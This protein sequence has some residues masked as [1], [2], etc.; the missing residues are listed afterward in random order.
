MKKIFRSTL[1]LSMALGLVQFTAC[2]GARSTVSAQS[3]QAAAYVPLEKSLLWEISGNGLTKPSYLFGTIHLI[4]KSEFFFPATLEEKLKA[5]ERAT[6]EID[7]DEMSSMESMF[8]I[9]GKAFMKDGLTLRDLL[10]EAEYKVVEDHFSEKGLP[11]QFL[12]RMKPMLLATFASLDLGQGGLS[13]TKSYEMEIFARVNEQNKPSDGLETVDDQLSIFD[14]IPYQTQAKMLM[15][16]IKSSDT[17]NEEYKKLIE[18]YKKQDIETLVKISVGEGD[19]GV[20]EHAD[21]FLY[22]RNRNW[23]PHMSRM[24][25]EKP[26]FFAVGAGHLGGPQG[27]INLLKKAGFKV[28]AVK[29]GLG[30]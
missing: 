9:I 1:Y 12:D 15:E 25:K 14:S 23:I 4:D 5:C 20:G 26:T 22:Q 29:M 19:G 7:M 3:G 10:T 11:L 27:V 18:L 24:M 8:K 30:A 13:D 2:S 21:L 17:E 16:S 6:F 28:S